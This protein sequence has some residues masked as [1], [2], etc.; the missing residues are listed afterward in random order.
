MEMQKVRMEMDGKISGFDA[1]AF[2]AKPRDCLTGY[3]LNNNAEN[4][5]FCKRIVTSE[6]YARVSLIMNGSM[7]QTL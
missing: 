5:T 2:E 1:P 3:K 4:W 6:P 7:D